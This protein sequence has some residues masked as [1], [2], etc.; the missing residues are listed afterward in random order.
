M[1][2][3]KIKN[4]KDLDEIVDDMINKIESNTADYEL[5]ETHLFTMLLPESYWGDGS[6]NKWIRVGWALKNTSNILLPT[7]LKFCSQ[8]KEFT[9]NQIN[10]LINRWYKFDYNQEG[11]TSRSIMYWA[12]N[13]NP[14]EYY[15]IRNETISYFIEQTINNVTEWDFAQVLY[16]ICKDEFVCVSIKNNI[17]YEY[18]SHRW[19]EIDSGNT[20]RLIIS[21]RMHDI[22]MKKT[23]DTVNALQKIDIGNENHELLRK[24]SNKLTDLCLLLKKTNWKNN[25]MREAKELF[26]DKDFYNKLDNN[27]NLLCF[28]NFVVDFKNNTIR[29]GQP[30]DY[31]SKCTNIDYIPYKILNESY[32]EIVDEIN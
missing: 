14:K 32:K 7:W 6:Y 9:Y 18:I 16:Q 30:D 19:F 11:L 28:N 26:Y 17:W 8:S 10:D 3:S 20:L 1:E 25:I 13:D 29:N 23:T 31:I 24:R 12:K 4:S 27:P 21:K 5:K 2:I 15:K 22:Y